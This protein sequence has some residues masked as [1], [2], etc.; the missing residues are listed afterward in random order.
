M[1]EPENGNRMGKF[2]GALAVGFLAMGLRIGFALAAGNPIPWVEAVLVGV[3]LAAT[4]VWL[5]NRQT[6]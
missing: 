3:A 5:S 2:V 1:P 6:G 4:V